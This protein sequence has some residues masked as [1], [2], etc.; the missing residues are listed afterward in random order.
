MTTIKYYSQT[1]SANQ[2]VRVH[3]V[4]SF[5]RCVAGAATFTV[6]P[7]Q[8]NQVT[9]QEGI[10]IRYEQNFN[11]IVLVNGSTAQ[12]VTLY[13][14]D[15]NLDDSRLYG[16]IS[17]LP[18]GA[19]AATMVADV[20]LNATE[21]SAIAANANRTKIKIQADIN[22]TTDLRVGTT[23]GDSQGFVLTPG[24]LLEFTHQAAITIRNPTGGAT[25]QVARYEYETQT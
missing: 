8:Q 24:A 1:L 13:I 9:M 19:E 18:V 25:A 23:V 20:S 16:N 21:E 11:S 12:T 3:Q 6:E 10:G 7:D 17:A 22:N 14:G 2:R 5:I 15:G 4:G